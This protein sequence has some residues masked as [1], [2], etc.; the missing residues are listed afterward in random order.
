MEPCCGAEPCDDCTPTLDSYVIGGVNIKLLGTGYGGYIRVQGLI[1]GVWT[2]IGNLISSALYES[3]GVIVEPTFGQTTLRVWGFDD[4]CDYGYSEPLT[5]CMGLKCD[6]SPG[7]VVKGVQ[8]TG[9]SGKS[10]LI[11]WGDGNTT[12]VLMDGAFHVYTNSYTAGDY[13]LLIS[14]DTDEVTFLGVPLADMTAYSGVE[15][16]P[17]LVTLRLDYNNISSVNDGELDNLTA[18]QTI[19]MEHNSINGL[20]DNYFDGATALKS[21]NFSYN[22]IITVYAGWFDNLNNLQQLQF[23]FNSIHTLPDN[24]FDNNSN[25]ILLSFGN[26]L[27]T[28]LPA[29]LLQLNTLLRLVYFNDNSLT[30]TYVDYVFNEVNSYGTTSPPLTYIV[31]MDGGTNAAPTGGALNADIVALISRNWTCY[32]N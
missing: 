18:L 5:V 27:L 2:N 10:I 3:G 17:A 30:V 13:T 32:Y 25:L 29:N 31:A 24:L 9:T 7:T 11:N 16:F 8:L 6:I 26:N 15:C 19:N 1:G 12:N 20:F 23:Q 21:I 22:A 14:G 4:D 28:N